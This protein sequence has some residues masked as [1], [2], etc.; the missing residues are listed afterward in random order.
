MIYRPLGQL[1]RV[2]HMCVHKAG[3]GGP[4]A[5]PN[6]PS[7]AGPGRLTGYLTAI[8]ASPAQKLSDPR[9]I[10]FGNTPKPLTEPARRSSTSMA[11]A[12][13]TR[14][15]SPAAASPSAEYDRTP[16]QDIPAETVRF[17]AA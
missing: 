16:P 12:D 6:V 9:D 14:M 8:H 15:S 17:S 3:C 2:L 7:E 5:T 10:H 4:G 1:H 13:D 11:L